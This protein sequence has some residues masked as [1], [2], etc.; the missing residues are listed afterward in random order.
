MERKTLLIQ[1]NK[2]KIDNLLQL[3]NDNYLKNINDCNLLLNEHIQFIKIT[4]ITN[5]I[6]L[7]KWKDF[8][9]R[10]KILK[11]KIMKDNKL[12][13][14]TSE[15]YSNTIS[16]Y[17]KAQSNDIN[18][19][20][21]KYEEIKENVIIEFAFLKHEHNHVAQFIKRKKQ[22]IIIDKDYDN[23]ME[24]LYD[25]NIKI[26]KIKKHINLIKRQEAQFILKYGIILT[27]LS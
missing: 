2:L 12:I 10:Y 1:N 15:I 22:F 18:N 16:Y 5:I 6:D 26:N 3:C 17:T 4:K 23:C 13:N 19:I 7:S 27:N 24:L 8:I 14:K 11:F 20:I 9:N 25:I 21:T